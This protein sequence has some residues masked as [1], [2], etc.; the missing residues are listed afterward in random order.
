MELTFEKVYKPVDG[1]QN[2]AIDEATYFL[3]DYLTA[4]ARLVL[5]RQDEHWFWQIRLPCA[6]EVPLPSAVTVLTTG[7]FSPKLEITRS[8]YWYALH[9]RT[10]GKDLTS[11]FNRTIGRV[12]DLP[13]ESLFG[14]MVG[15]FRVIIEL[16]GQLE[17]L[18]GLKD[19]AMKVFITTNHEGVATRL[20]QWLDCRVYP[21]DTRRP[22]AVFC[23]VGFSELHYFIRVPI[24]SDQY[25]PQL[26][27]V[28]TDVIEFIRKNPNALQRNMLIG[29]LPGS[30]KTTTVK[31]VVSHVLQH[32]SL[33]SILITD[34]KGEY[35]DWSRAHGVNHLAIGQDPTSL[36][37]LGINLFI[38]PSNLRLATYI[39]LLAVLL[40][41][42]GF[43][44]GGPLL[45]SYM[46]FLLEEYYIAFLLPIIRMDDWPADGN[47]RRL[48][49]LNLSGKEIS[50]R[51]NG[52][53]SCFNGANRG[54]VRFWSN[55]S[56][57][58]IERVFGQG[59]RS[60][61]RAEIE[62]VIATR[63]AS[64][65]TSILQFFCYTDGASMDRLLSEHWCFSL[66]GLPKATIQ[67]VMSIFY[68]IGFEML[69]AGPEMNSLKH[70]FLI[71]ESHLVAEQTVASDEIFTVG[72]LIGD[73]IER[74]LSEARSKGVGIILTD[75]QPGTRL[76]SSVLANT[77]L[78][79]CHNILGRDGELM[80][81]AMGLPL[82]TNFSSLGVGE[83]Y[84]K[85]ADNLPPVRSRI[86][87]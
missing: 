65:E 5:G 86:R 45:P 12:L 9:N 42:A 19:A 51:L 28:P 34:I 14:S 68:M 47:L 82:E 71:E 79:I 6:N 21:L 10:T 35:S 32:S 41:I 39:D 67:L 57:V 7:N 78:K 75:Q 53:L 72:K 23:L 62:D 56:A 77:N 66:N 59:G 50:D 2:S 22:E 15:N 31:K 26:K 13:L 24:Y 25:L 76:L 60:N 3:K 81:K 20:G 69:L 74:G 55:H 4:G 11:P 46:K 83:A 52:D 1:A 87:L 43:G 48:W 73:I 33:Q 38:P 84:V 27:Y 80:A 8:G 44:G 40:S 70:L 63:I 29:G 49:L 18:P 54:L 58:F 30:G 85:L 36:Y 37:R 64:F 16:P 17:Q 61:G